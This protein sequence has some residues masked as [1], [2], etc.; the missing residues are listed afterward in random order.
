M[1]D[2]DASTD[3]PSMV[4]LEGVP[5]HV[6]RQLVR[7]LE[8]LRT[9]EVDPATD[10]KSA[11]DLITTAQAVSGWAEWLEIEGIRRLV[12]TIEQDP[13]ID[14]VEREPRSSARTQR[15][16]VRRAAALE[17]QVLTGRSLS[18]CRD[19]VAL[20]SATQARSGYLRDRLAS[21]TT[22]A[23]R[24]MNVVKETRHLDPL[25]A[26]RI[27][28]SVLRPLG[29]VATDPSNPDG[30]GEEIAAAAEAGVPLSQATFRRR[31][32]A[33]LTRAESAQGLGERLTAEAVAGR[34]LRTEPGNFGMAHH[35]DHRRARPRVRGGD[36]H[37]PHGAGRPCW[38]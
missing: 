30:V 11:G 12:A 1:A 3:Y 15:A 8:L 24:A 9:S 31:L 10:L 29:E 25:T 13:A 33:E 36:A 6:A 35:V 4:S 37:R 22:C 16:E 7:V 21:G 32:R 23:H 34:D 19:R 28:R 38:W 14:L 27:A 5:A 2:H 17:V 20:A 26:D 18:Q